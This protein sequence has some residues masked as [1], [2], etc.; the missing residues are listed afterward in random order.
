MRVLVT[1]STG[2]VGHALVKR[3]ID[4]PS[5]TP[6]AG[7]RRANTVDFGC[8]TYVLGDLTEPVNLTE[9]LRGVDV[10]VH[11]AARAHVLNVGDP[12]A[13]RAEFESVN[14]A[15]TRRLAIAAR[16]AGVRRLIFLSSIGVHGDRTENPFTADSPFD[17]RSAYAHSK[18]QAEAALQEV[19]AGSDT[20]W[21]VIRP[22]LVYGPNAP[23]NMQKLLGLV[24]RAPPIPLAHVNNQRS[25]VALPNLLDLV[26]TC[27]T[28]TE[29]AG[30]AWLV[31]DGVDLSTP[32][33]IRELADG[34][35]RPARLFP[36]PMSWLKALGK[37]T[38][39]AGTISSLTDDLQLDIQA[40]RERLGWKPVIRPE[41][42]LRH[43]AAWFR[44]Q[45]RY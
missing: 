43:T 20:E 14:V 18:A 28:H 12:L 40:T 27:A 8:E 9:R 23:G 5:V 36:M 22:P 6:I 4:I 44:H 11:T 25:L 24:L 21:V 10:I 38:G 19:L 35:G 1:G 7:C 17:P 15:A 41:P 30:R 13:E 37:V 45:R 33:L 32:R 31:A 3:L 29:A 39:R 42:V 2:F 16:R 34:M 26:L